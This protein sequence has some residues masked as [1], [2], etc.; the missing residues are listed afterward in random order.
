MPSCGEIVVEPNSGQGWGNWVGKGDTRNAEGE[1]VV[2][3]EVTK[4]SVTNVELSG[5]TALL[6]FADVKFR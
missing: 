2:M 5:I 4:G 6:V 3:V 1:D